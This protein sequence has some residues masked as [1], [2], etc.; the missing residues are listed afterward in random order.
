MRAVRSDSESKREQWSLVT[1]PAS[2]VS[3]RNRSIEVGGL[4]R[5][6]WT[7]ARAADK[8]SLVIRLRRIALFVVLLTVPFQAAVGA[9]GLICGHGTHHSQHSGS[10]I[11]SNFDLHHHG[12]DAAAPAHQHQHHGTHAHDEN[13]AGAHHSTS[14]SNDGPGKCSICVECCFSAAPIPASLPE[15][16]PPDTPLKVSDHVSPAMSSRA[17]DG[18]FRP[19]RA[20]TS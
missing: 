1:C 17:G 18:L 2:K 3:R 11:D 5:S 12:D 6:V 15:L 7:L 16:A 13:G 19:P 8:L 20:I 14:G 10:D 9:I 4:W